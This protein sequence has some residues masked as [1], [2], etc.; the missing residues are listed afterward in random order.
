MGAN[1][2]LQ[3]PP[4]AVHRHRHPDLRDAKHARDFRIAVALEETQRKNLRRL[5]TQARQRA[6]QAFAP[7]A[8]LQLSA[9]GQR[10]R[11]RR[12]LRHLPSAHDIERGIDRRAAKIPLGIL[13]L[14]S[15]AVAADETQENRLKYVLGV[16]K[17]TGDPVG[18]TKDQTV[19]CTEQLFNCIDG[20]GNCY[21]RSG[22]SHARLLTTAIK[23][24]TSHCANYYSQFNNI[25]KT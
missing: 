11:Q 23:L 13:H 7:F 20:A 1:L 5:R 6:P 21:L 3:P 22:R 10:I 24:K 2:L 15:R 14:R 18:G 19:V 25:L 17:I 16:G 8:P 4:G 9:R 12:A